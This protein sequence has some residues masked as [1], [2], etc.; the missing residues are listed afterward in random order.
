MKEENKLALG[1]V[2]RGAEERGGVYLKDLLCLKIQVTRG[3][4]QLLSHRSRED[5]RC[6]PVACPAYKTSK[7]EVYSGFHLSVEK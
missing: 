1:V 6:Y 3:I 2:G 4:F 7:A 5:K